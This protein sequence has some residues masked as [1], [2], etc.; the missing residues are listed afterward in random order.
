MERKEIIWRRFENGIIA[1]EKS[2]ADEL[3]KFVRLATSVPEYYK[4]FEVYDIQRGKKVL[5]TVRLKKLLECRKM[6]PF[7]FLHWRN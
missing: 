4:L 2:H 6:P 5:S 1:R 3:E 7:N